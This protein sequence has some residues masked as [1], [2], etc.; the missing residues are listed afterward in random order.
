[1]NP[2]LLSSWQTSWSSIKARGDGL[3]LMQRLIAAYQ[4]S[5]RRYHTLQHLLEC[6]TL[7]DEHRELALAPGE[8]GIA[9]W[10]HD[11]V[12]DPGA[13][14]NEAASAEWAQAELR[15]AQLPAHQI[16][17]ISQHILATRHAA[18][19]QGSDQ[20]L[21]VDIDLAILGAARSRFIEYEA[22]VRAEYNWVADDS[23]REKRSAL[24]HD[25][26]AREHLY[27]TPA[28]RTLFESRARAN[29]AYSL[30][31]LDPHAKAARTRFGPC[32]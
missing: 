15:E 23:Y 7:F 6:L 22:Q 13:N 21:L 32:R 16:E 28:L 19:P 18:L 24:L 5:Q 3:P 27:T 4:E 30:Q 31:L 9:L 20:S 12:Y 1:M 25:L 8:V 17:C 29:L 14:G 26:L 11:A 10:F 2:V